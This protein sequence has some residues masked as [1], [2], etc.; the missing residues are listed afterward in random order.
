MMGT[1]G[2]HKLAWENCGSRHTSPLLSHGRAELGRC[3]KDTVGENETFL[4]NLVAP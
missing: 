4:G 1:G 2:S 3:R